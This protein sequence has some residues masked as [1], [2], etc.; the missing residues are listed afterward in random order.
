[1]GVTCENLAGCHF[2]SMLSSKRKTQTPIKHLQI[3]SVLSI[4]I[5]FACML[6]ALENTVSPERTVLTPSYV[7]RR[8]SWNHSYLGKE[9]E[10]EFSLPTW[11]YIYIYTY[12]YV[13]IYIYVYIY[14]YIYIYTFTNIC[15][16]LNIH[17]HLYTYVYIYVYIY[18]LMYAY[19]YRFT[20]IYPY[21]CT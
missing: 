20:L 11:N 13:C 16:R 19:I 5:R 3:S 6:L 12:T 21:T 18:T 2:L 7:I 14:I 1:M 15:I 17:M 10:R 9:R 4:N 8:I